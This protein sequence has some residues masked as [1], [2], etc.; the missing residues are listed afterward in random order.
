MA[1]Q[2]NYV[3]STTALSLTASGTTVGSGNTQAGAFTDLRSLVRGSIGAGELAAGSQTWVVHTEVTATSGLFGSRFR[4]ERRNS[5][6]AVQST[7]PYTTAHE[8]LTTGTYDESVTWDSGV[9]AANDQ[10]ALVWQGYRTGGT[11]NKTGTIGANGASYVDA[12]APNIYAKTGYGV[13]H[14]VV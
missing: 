12:P 2:R 4:L 6:G 10:L 3:V 8:P 14:R 1:A 7:S 13:E 11:G 5:L 9:W